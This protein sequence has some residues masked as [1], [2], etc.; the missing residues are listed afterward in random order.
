MVAAMNSQAAATL[1]GERF[2]N[3]LGGYSK[4][5]RRRNE[6]TNKQQAKM[7]KTRKGRRETEGG[8]R[9]VRSQK[10]ET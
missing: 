9:K 1:T 8:E 2:F 10:P 4:N 6:K 5:T 3:F 7:E